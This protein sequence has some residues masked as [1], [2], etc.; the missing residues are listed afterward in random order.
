[1]N[2][3]HLWFGLDKL[4]VAFE[5]PDLPTD[6]IKV[7][8]I[9][10]HVFALTSSNSVY[11]SEVNLN[12]EDKLI[13]SNTD[14]SAIDIACNNKILYFVSSNGQVFKTNPEDLDIKEEII[15][16]EDAKCCSHG[17]KTS[18]QR[19]RVKTIAAEECSCLYVTENGQLW[20]SGNQPKLGLHD[21][22]P[23][24]V[25]F[26]KKRYVISVACG[27]NFSI[28]LVYKPG[29]Y[30]PDKGNSDSDDDSEDVFVS[31]CPVCISSP[32]SQ[33]S[34]SETCPLGLQVQHTSDEHFST[35]STSKETTAEDKKST[36]DSTSASTNGNTDVKGRSCDVTN[37]LHVQSNSDVPTGESSQSFIEGSENIRRTEK[38]VHS[39]ENIRR[40]EKQV[41][42]DE[43]EPES[44]LMKEEKKNEFFINTEAARQ[45]LTRQ[46]SWVSGYGGAGED[47]VECAEASL[48]RPSRIIK[49]NMSNV[50]S[51]VYEGVKTVGD[52]GAIL[53]RHMSGGSETNESIRGRLV[54]CGSFEE[55]N[56]EEFNTAAPS[57]TSSLRYCVRNVTNRCFVSVFSKHS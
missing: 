23:Q 41:H 51:L 39:S 30:V 40:T 37:K 29:H 3:V 28:A 57:I 42:S 31:D 17:Y 27:A 35:S 7:C 1:M 50:A 19:V 9:N 10:H 54:D 15:L 52:R 32:T 20:V 24:K 56:A 4:P 34:A 2:E 21:E 48:A 22:V 25:A 55:L 16:K 49:Q 8:K 12:C 44:E 46:L 13:F 14:I 38:Q 6:I 45:F 5:P 18:E 47:L 43:N 33:Q 26:F 53:F 36:D 11:H